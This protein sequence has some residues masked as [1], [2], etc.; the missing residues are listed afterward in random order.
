MFWKNTNCIFV[1]IFHVQL[2][3]CKVWIAMLSLWTL[4]DTRYTHWF[5]RLQGERS[6]QTCPATHWTANMDP[7][8]NDS[9]EYHQIQSIGSMRYKNLLIWLE[10]I[11]GYQPKTIN[12]SV[13]NVLSSI[14]T[15]HHKFYY[16]LCHSNK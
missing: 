12:N 8:K 4:P 15:Y 1:S 16:F 11:K 9:D 2:S 14:L 6:I 10:S 3:F 5:C 7:Y 13:K